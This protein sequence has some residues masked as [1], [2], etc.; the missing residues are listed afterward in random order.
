[1]L[2]TILVTNFGAND[3]YFVRLWRPYNVAVCL[4]RS[5]G[6]RGRSDDGVRLQANVQRV[7]ADH[8][9]RVRARHHGHR[10]GVGFR[11]QTD[12]DR[13]PTTGAGPVAWQP[14]D[15]RR[16]GDGRGPGGRHGGHAGGRD[17]VA[18]AEGAA[19]RER[20]PGRQAHAAVS[21]GRSGRRP[22][23]S[24]TQDIRSALGS[25]GQPGGA[26][27]P[28]QAQE[29]EPFHRRS[30]RARTW[31]ENGMGP[32]IPASWPPPTAEANV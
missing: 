6:R 2:C 28:T 7:A 25:A 29:I 1:M 9:H 32:I 3:G 5:T 30:T 16:R 21:S 15:G 31:P 23:A 12:V 24:G 22:G 26:D 13:G 27:T 18:V 10:A 8:G 4:D 11:R 17:R 14:A 20:D 19:R